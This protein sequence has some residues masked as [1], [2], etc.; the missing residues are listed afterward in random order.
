[1]TEKLIDFETA[2]LAK[3][4]GFN[5]DC[6][7]HFENTGISFDSYG[8]SFKPNEDQ[9]HEILFAR[10]TQSFLQKWL[11]EI[12]DI[13]ISVGNVYDDF[14]YWSFALS[15]QN[16]G[17]IIAFRLN[18]IYYSSYEEALEIALQESLNLIQQ[19]NL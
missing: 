14:I 5:E 7:T 17:V 12:H 6:N 3:E 15:Q 11:R 10:P 4:K 16:K 9:H 13:H 18:D 2:V 19:H 8:L 1:M